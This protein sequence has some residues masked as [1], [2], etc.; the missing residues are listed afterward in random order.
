MFPSQKCSF[1][2]IKNMVFKASKDPLR[3]NKAMLYFT[4][5]G[6]GEE[7]KSKELSE[8]IWLVDIRVRRI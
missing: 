1:R 8:V 4:D 7:Q 2:Q 3:L 6:L 5:K